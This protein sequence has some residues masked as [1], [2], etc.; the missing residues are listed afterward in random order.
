MDQTLPAGAKQVI[1]MENY[2]PGVK[3]RGNGG[4]WGVAGST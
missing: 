3:I 4:Q 2:E 1:E